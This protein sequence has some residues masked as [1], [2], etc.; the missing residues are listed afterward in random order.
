MSLRDIKKSKLKF[1]K[2]KLKLEE[3]TKI[4]FSKIEKKIIK[5]RNTPYED[6]THYKTVKEFF[7]RSAEMYPNESCI[8]EKPNHQDPYKE[9][10]YKEFYGTWNI[11]N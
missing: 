3:I 4:D 10:T 6:M 7:T 8:L 9:I 2:M 11:F 5:K 1:K